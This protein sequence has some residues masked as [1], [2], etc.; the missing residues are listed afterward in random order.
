[1]EKEIIISN[2]YHVKRKIGEGG[3]AKVY[4]AYDDQ[5]SLDVALKIL[6][7]ENVDE[8]KVKS[9]KREARTLG[10]LDDPNI[11]CIY[12]V[13]EENGI[14]YIA[15]E[16]VEGMSLKEYISTCAPIPVEEVIK[17][18]NQI[19]SGLKH[20]HNKGVVHKDIKSQNILLD[21]KRNV[22]IT[23]LGIADI[24]DE[25]ITRTQSLMGTPQYVAPE[26]LNRDE[27]TAQ[28]DIY[29][30]G[31]LMYE[32]L[33]GKAPF[34]GDKPAIIMIKQM[35]HPLPSIKEQRLDVPQ[36]LEN[37]AIKASAKKLENRYK[38]VVE[39]QDDLLNIQQGRMHVPKL[40]LE[41]DLIDDKKL[42]QTIILDTVKI[43]D[44]FEKTKPKKKMSLRRL[45]LI[46][47]LIILV[48]FS[49]KSFQKKPDIMPDLHAKSIEEVQSNP[50]FD[51]HEFSII[52]SYSSKE[53]ENNVISTE[54]AAGKPIIEG[55]EVFITIS[56]GPKEKELAD[57]VGTKISVTKNEL[58][59]LDY[60]VNINEVDSL[61]DEGTIIK[62]SPAPLE[63]IS[64]GTTINF[65]VS[66]G[67]IETTVPN[68]IGLKY[69]EVK[70]WSDENGIE[71]LENK[72]CN[73]SNFEKDTIYQQN[74][75]YNSEITS[76]DKITIDVLDADCHFS[77]EQNN[78]ENK[79][80]TDQ[81]N[82]DQTD[83][84]N[85]D[86]INDSSTNSDMTDETD[87]EQT[88]NSSTNS[89]SEVEQETNNS[90]NDPDNQQ[91]SET[92]DN[93]QQEQAGN[94]EAANQ[95]TGSEENEQASDDLT[96]ENQQ[97]DLQ[98]EQENQ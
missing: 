7:K 62:Q 27:L 2:R 48:V 6:K 71:L 94:E 98:E 53:A 50:L 69:D 39:M 47:L 63:K 73:Q 84:A 32:M 29:S 15:N 92:T 51:K 14:H 1:M 86:Q 20:A 18:T 28:S 59:S 66:K 49:I 76:G 64:Y 8:K 5:L 26:I 3:M 77:N 43:S 93:T 75:T 83:Q 35:N 72:V 9:F 19:L 11:V 37:I 33:V 88:D 34:T 78:Q 25:E 36:A 74:P 61:Q 46:T 67:K 81:E 41:N 79:K 40:I 16:F 65:D 60:H 45:F 4:L 21:T 44:N 58:E 55:Q 12:D 54:P 57:Y 95:T 31:I 85:K 24:I 23:D 97:N 30:V 68:F 38:T 70:K 90:E 10:L 87:K 96:E 91:N 89:D 56:R 82:K 17:I 13:G 42:E 52:Y 22:K 80:Q